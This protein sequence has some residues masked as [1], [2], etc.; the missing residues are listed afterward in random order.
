[1]KDALVIILYGLCCIITYMF[2]LDSRKVIYSDFEYRKV[3]LERAIEF[4]NFS[5]MN[6]DVMKASNDF[7]KFLKGDKDE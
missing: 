4:S 3:A 1:M 7:Y 5:Q 6:V 2:F